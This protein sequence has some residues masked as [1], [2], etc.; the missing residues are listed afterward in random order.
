MNIE[1]KRRLKAYITGHDSEHDV[2][3]VLKSIAIKKAFVF[4]PPC[5]KVN[6][7]KKQ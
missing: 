3:E 7:I 1:D 4:K 5:Y 2:I 6:S